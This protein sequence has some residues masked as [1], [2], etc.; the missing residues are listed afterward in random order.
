MSEQTKAFLI[1]L[2]E[3]P[4]T[5]AEV[6]RNASA[7]MTEHGVPEA[8]Q[9]LIL[10]GDKQQLIEVAGLDEAQARFMIV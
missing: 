9:Q 3:N 8:H 6:R 2:G 4:N 5:L 10:S 7:V 1:K